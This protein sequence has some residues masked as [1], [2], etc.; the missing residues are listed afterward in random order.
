[1]YPVNTSTD[2][3]QIWSRQMSSVHVKILTTVAAKIG[4][5]PVVN[6]SLLVIRPFLKTYG[7]GL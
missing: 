7:Q 4:N 1:M 2:G 6:L 5:P 3:F